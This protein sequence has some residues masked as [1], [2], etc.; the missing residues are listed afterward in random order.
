MHKITF[1]V[2]FIIGHGLVIKRYV[3]GGTWGYAWIYLTHWSW[4]LMIV[5]YLY[6]TL[7]VLIR[8]VQENT[9]KSGKGEYFFEKNHIS[10]MISWALSSTAN[11]VA[12]CVTLA[13]WTALYDPSDPEL[14][15][16]LAKFNNFDVHLIQVSILLI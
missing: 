4:I 11:G 3:D 1:S 10:T 13:Y 15:P 12:I 6:N 5:S 9:R 14:S 7:L 16:V 2:Y 8:F